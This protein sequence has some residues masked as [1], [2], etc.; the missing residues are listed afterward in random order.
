MP[1]L[2]FPLHDVLIV[3]MPYGRGSGILI[4]SESSF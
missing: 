2:N 4:G 3:S 1:H